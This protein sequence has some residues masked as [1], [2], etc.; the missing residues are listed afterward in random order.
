MQ[1]ILTRQRT[2]FAA[3][4][5]FV[6]ASISVISA[7]RSASVASRTAAHF[8]ATTTSLSDLSPNECLTVT[9]ALNRPASPCKPILS[10]ELL[11]NF[12][13]YLQALVSVPHQL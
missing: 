6:V 11:S 3:S 13:T 5:A 4:A 2:L 1:S 9:A 12:H 7:R 8:S 10:Q